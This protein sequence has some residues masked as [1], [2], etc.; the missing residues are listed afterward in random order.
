[1]LAGRRLRRLDI[2]SAKVAAHLRGEQIHAQIEGATADQ[3]GRAA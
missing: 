1:V 2:P 3:P